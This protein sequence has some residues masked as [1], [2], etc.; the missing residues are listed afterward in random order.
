MSYSE[1]VLEHYENPRNVGSLPKDDPS[2]GTGM[3]GA[4]AC[5]DVMKLQIRVNE[6]GVIED[7]KF[8]TYGCLAGNV[9]IN[10]P[11]KGIP[12]RDLRIGDEVLAWNGHFISA[13]KVEG[14]RKREVPLSDL[15]KVVLRRESSRR[16]V[17]PLPLEI[18][19]AK[20]HV[21]WGA[22][23]APVPAEEL[24]AGMEILEITESELRSMTNV[25]KRSGLRERMSRRMAEFNRHFDHASLPQNSKGYVHGDSFRRKLSE[26]AKRLWESEEY[27]RNWREGMSRIDWSKPTK[28][29]LAFMRLFQDLDLPIERVAGKKWIQTSQGP[30]SPD[31]QV[32]GKKK[33]IETYCKSLPEFM[34]DR[35]EGSGYERERAAALR[36]AGYET[37]FLAIEDILECNERLQRFVH[38]G[39]EVLAAEPIRHGNELR[40]VEVDRERKIALL[41]DLE[42][43]DGANV[44]FASRAGCHNCGSA[45]ASSSL[46]TEWVKGKTL[47]E[48]E[49][50]KNTEIAEELALPPVK[51]HCSVLAEDAIKSA[52]ADYKAKLAAKSGEGGDR[53]IQSSSILGEER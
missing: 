41:Y 31:F 3:V 39:L 34:Q 5:G 40:G 26:S 24:R 46:V 13:A 52:I 10:T 2:V 29:E 4:P 9:L 8:K 23:G 45:I 42:L 53:E 1:K 21:F 11:T 43:A 27:V 35:S 7:A 15:R 18:I 6:R 32:K 48:A 16:G 14:I 20:D 17:N 50:I 33:L 36:E 44:Y 51:I 49:Q 25:R 38:N 22:Q 30:M 28:V 12:M 19:C 47:E 37:L